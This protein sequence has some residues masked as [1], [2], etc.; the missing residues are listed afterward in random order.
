MESK[1]IRPI[2]DFPF[3]EALSHIS[4]QNFSKKSKTSKN[5]SVRLK[6]KAF[7]EISSFY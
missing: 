2:L 4:F 1:T 7:S 5:S 3:K 6:F